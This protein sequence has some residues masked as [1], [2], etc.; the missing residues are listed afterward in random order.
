MMDCPILN[1]GIIIGDD[2]FGVRQRARKLSAQS[3]QQRAKVFR[4]LS[5]VGVVISK[6]GQSR[7]KLA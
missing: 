3:N 2:F 4:S 6:H 7:L 1:P 5:Y